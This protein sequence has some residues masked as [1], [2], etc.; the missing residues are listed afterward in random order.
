MAVFAV[1]AAQPQPELEK[2]IAD[3]FP[4]AHIRVND[5]TWL[6]ES[7]SLPGMLADQL[8]LRAGARGLA[9]VIQVEPGSV[10][11][12]QPKSTW[13]WLSLKAAKAAT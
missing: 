9:L 12:W 7:D 13:G 10:S 6:V 1:I 3:L 2:R 5:R 11:G 4:A 8:E